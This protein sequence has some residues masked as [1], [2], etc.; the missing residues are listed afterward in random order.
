MSD[1]IEPTD[2][3]EKAIEPLAKDVEVIID[4]TEGLPEPQREAARGAAFRLAMQV[5]YT[6][7]FTSPMP[8]PAVMRGYEDIHAG[9]FDRILS[10][11]ERQM[12]H[13]HQIENKVID[14]DITQA[15]RGLDRGF[16]VVMTVL[17][18][19]I[20]L[21]GMGRDISGLILSV[22]SLV[23]LGGLFVYA[24]S[25]RNSERQSRV[26]ELTRPQEKPQLPENPSSPES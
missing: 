2:D 17:I 13:R 5:S 26:K 25:R 23:G 21:L 19:G 16:I 22:G 1:A 12:E 18:G 11:T 14:S 10:L 15:H 4:A 8:P 3:G 20:V 9:A 6:E 7:S 24:S